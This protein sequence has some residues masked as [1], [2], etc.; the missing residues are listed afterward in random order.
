MKITL[1]RSLLSLLCLA[2]SACAGTSM[3][4]NSLRG[5]AAATA[6][7]APL[8]LSYGGRKPGQFALI[9]RS[10]KGQPPLIPHTLEGIGEITGSENDC[11]DCHISED[12]RGKKMPRVGQSHLLASASAGAEPELNMQRWQCNSCHVPQV[13]A[14]PLVENLFQPDAAR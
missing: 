6:D 11:L 12:F 9:E 13:E 1:I 10:F 2:L 14:M 3:P 7:Q 4:V 8:V 5:S